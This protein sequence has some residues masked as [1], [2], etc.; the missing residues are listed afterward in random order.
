[1][2]VPSNNRIFLVTDDEATECDIESAPP[3]SIEVPVPSQESER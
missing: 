3:L 1:M 2:K